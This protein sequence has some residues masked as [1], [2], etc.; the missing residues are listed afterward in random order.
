MAA[1]PA[2]EN[3]RPL[4]SVIWQETKN[5]IYK[6]NRVVIPIFS[7]LLFATA[8]MLFI[9]LPAINLATASAIALAEYKTAAIVAILS[10]AILTGVLGSK[11]APW[12]DKFM[13]S[14]FEI[15]E[16]VQGLAPQSAKEQ[17]RRE[18]SHLS[19]L[20]CDLEDYEFPDYPL[21]M[22]QGALDIV[23]RRSYIHYRKEETG[24]LGLVILHEAEML[25]A[26]NPLP[27]KQQ[28]EALEA[29]YIKYGSQIKR[30]FLKIENLDD[31]L[32][33]LKKFKNLNLVLENAQLN[34]EQIKALSKLDLN[35]LELKNCTFQ[36]ADLDKIKEKTPLFISDETTI[37]D[38]L[39][40][41]QRAFE[42]EIE[43]SIITPSEGG[44]IRTLIST[45][46]EDLSTN[47][48]T[49]YYQLARFGIRLNLA[50][51]KNQEDSEFF[52]QEFLK[53]GF[54]IKEL[55]APFPLTLSFFEPLLGKQIEVLKMVNNL[56][57]FSTLNLYLPYLTELH[58]D[59]EGETSDTSALLQQ[60]SITSIEKLVLR[61]K[62]DSVSQTYLSFVRSKDKEEYGYQVK[63]IKEG[64][65]QTNP[66]A[67]L[68]KLEQQV[69][70]SRGAE[71]SELIKIIAIDVSGISGLE[72][73]SSFTDL[74]NFCGRQ[75][76][77]S[78]LNLS[79]CGLKIGDF[80]G[81]RGNLKYPFM[82]Q[83]QSLDLSQNPAFNGN[84]VKVPDSVTVY[85]EGSNLIIE[86]L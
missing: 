11:I 81:N 83:L 44:N 26:V 74:F 39:D 20:V 46:I 77:L 15:I 72:K 85:T 86:K 29:A 57:D 4:P 10:S 61:R 53:Y 16:G 23:N 84:K 75:Q 3:K 55:E 45:F 28:R 37:S 58:L 82:S 47:P 17:K 51:F 69:T 8:F 76:N 42:D 40:Q 60:L 21:Q 56:G 13:R 9:A 25:G 33:I 7:N 54:V 79:N 27:E 50:S 36:A 71:K 63:L 1:I 43:S 14:L 22:I 2:T 66:L 5:V 12:K 41:L 62:I 19:R 18:N 31:F 59:F 64:V 32:P 70:R 38:N 34:Q 48:D 80:A 30:V 68:L 73:R 6:V 65:D 49:N 24:G 35:S 67:D 52:V 78:S